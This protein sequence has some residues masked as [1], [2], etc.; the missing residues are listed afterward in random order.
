M[1]ASIS[2]IIGGAPVQQGHL[3]QVQAE[4]AA[5]ALSVSRQA[6]DASRADLNQDAHKIEDA[7]YA[8]IQAMRALGRTRV[9]TA[10]IARALGL[11]TQVVDR[12]VSGLESKGVRVIG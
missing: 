4:L 1:S 12:A 8:H 2:M 7:V 10:Q 9:N 11:K 5:S 3:V 6:V